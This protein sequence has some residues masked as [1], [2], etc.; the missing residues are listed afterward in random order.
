MSKTLAPSS[1]AEWIASQAA[2]VRQECLNGLSDEAAAVALYDWPFW[3]RPS[4]R[5]PAGDWRI[6][7]LLAGR[8]FGKTRTGAEW[9]RARVDAGIARRI[10]LVAPTP[11]DARDVMIQGESG[12]LAIAPPWNRPLYEPSKRRLSWPN[13]THATI[14][15]GHEPDQ[16]RGPQH[17]T[18]WAD[19]LASW[20]YVRETWDNLQFGMRL[21]DDPQICVTTTPKPIKLLREL[22]AAPHVHV[23]TGT[24]YDNAANL[25]AAFFEQIVA[26]YEGTT[27]GQQE[28]HAALLDELPG[29]LLTRHVIEAARLSVAPLLRRI[30]V[31]IDPAATDKPESSETG[32]IVAGLGDNGHGYVL[33]DLSGRFTPDA[34]ARRAV[35]AFHTHK[36]NKLIGE[37]NNGGQMVEHTVHTVDKKVAYWPVVASRGKH[38]RAEPIAA[39]Y[40]QGRIHHI[41]AFPDLEDQW[42]TWMPGLPS[43]DRLDACV[44]ALS[45]LMLGPPPARSGPV[46]MERTSP[47]R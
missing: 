22:L 11:A 33:Q 15:S 42:C 38:T 16:L 45:D 14:Y 43:P 28:L 26:K 2:S 12:L 36:A 3:A 9:I 8:G 5:P 18:A 20:Q 13:G 27:L 21:G 7:L 40:E 6:W 31:A 39:L 32:I 41:G 47:W 37:Q 10:A 44:W 1:A 29:A 24:T 35:T 25:P 19:E 4:Q 30:V 23:T 34:W 17:D 46:S